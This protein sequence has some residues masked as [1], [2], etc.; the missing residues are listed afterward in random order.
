MDKSEFLLTYLFPFAARVKSETNKINFNI[1][2]LILAF[3]PHLSQF[4][5]ITM[6][7]KLNNVARSFT[8]SVK[9]EGFNGTVTVFVDKEN[10]FLDTEFESSSEYDQEIEEQIL[11][12]LDKNWETLTS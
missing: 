10:K 12:Y 9:T 6:N 1:P 2:N 7:I 4:L 5:S 3:A 8:F 11:D